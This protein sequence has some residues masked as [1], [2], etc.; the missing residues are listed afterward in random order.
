[1]NYETILVNKTP[2]IVTITINR[3]DDNNSINSSLINEINN[4]LDS[5]ESDPE[6]RIVV[7]EGQ[8]GVFLY[9]N[10]F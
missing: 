7:L 8:K 5:A 4:V 3:P 10:G 1:M 6:V 2:K 9:G